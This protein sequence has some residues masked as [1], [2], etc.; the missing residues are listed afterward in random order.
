MN[1]PPQEVPCSLQITGIQQLTG[2]AGGAY[3]YKGRRG[4]CW[5]PFWR[6]DGGE[7]VLLELDALA[8]EPS[9]HLRDNDAIGLWLRAGTADRRFDRGP[10][11]FSATQG[12][13]TVGI[14]PRQTIFHSSPTFRTIK[15][16]V[17]GGGGGGGNSPP[18]KGPS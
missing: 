1:R 18:T 4:G 5:V 10:G 8:C 12:T 13:R 2:A 3:R 9:D 11:G 17:G 16:R 6:N 7:V 15:G 14:S